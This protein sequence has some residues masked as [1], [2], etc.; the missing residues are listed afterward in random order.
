M[1]LSPRGLLGPTGRAGLPGVPSPAS[2]S[3]HRDF[4]NHIRVICS[5]VP[6]F[7]GR[8]GSVHWAAQCP[9]CAFSMEALHPQAAKLVLW[10]DESN[11]FLLCIK[12]RSTYS[13]KTDIPYIC[14][15][16]ISWG[17]RRHLGKNY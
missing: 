2:T 13:T 6:S 8:D 11:L 7:E 3:L 12:H 16:K 17:A 4:C 14:G 5:H 9:A 10:G 15:I 1:L